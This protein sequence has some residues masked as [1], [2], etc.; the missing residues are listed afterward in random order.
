MSDDHAA[1]IDKHVRTYILI[2]FAALLVLTVV[3]VAVS[4]LDLSVPMA[5]ALDC[6]SPRS[7]ARSWPATSCI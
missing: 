5:I 4:Y 3:T 7:R 2:V 6:S 1:D